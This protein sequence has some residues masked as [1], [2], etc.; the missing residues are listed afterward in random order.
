MGDGTLITVNDFAQDLEFNLLIKHVPGGFDEEQV[1]QLFKVLQPGQEVDTSLLAAKEV[2]L[3]LCA[4]A[5]PTG[6]LVGESS[7]GGSQKRP[8]S[9]D[10][11]TS[12]TAKSARTD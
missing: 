2:G 5:V 1:P 9:D 10:E 6:S 11:V 8:R 4:P 3:E 7:T 12:V